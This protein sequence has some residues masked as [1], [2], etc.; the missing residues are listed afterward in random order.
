MGCVF[1]KVEM[2][3]SC[4]GFFSALTL[5]L[6][7]SLMHKPVFASEPPIPANWTKQ[8]N[9]AQTQYLAADGSALVLVGPEPN[10]GQPNILA[11]AE[12]T[13]K[14]GGCQGL[15]K[16]AVQTTDRGVQKLVLNTGPVFCAIFVDSNSAPARLAVAI[17]QGTNEAVQYAE[18]LTR[19]WGVAK[20]SA[21]N[22]SP[23]PSTLSTGAVQDDVALKNAMAAVPKSNR[24][25][26][27]AVQSD[28]LLGANGAMQMTT[29]NWGV[30][31]NGYATD[32]TGWDPA[33]ISPTPQSLG[34]AMQKAGKSCH[35]I[36][37]EKKQGNYVRFI[38]PENVSV[39]DE[40]EIVN[41]GFA[42]GTRIDVSIGN[43]RA[44][45]SVGYVPDGMVAARG[46]S[47]GSLR[48]T[49]AGAIE[50]GSWSSINFT[51]SDVIAGGSSSSS[52]P[53]AGRY[54]LD[55][56]VIAIQDQNG[57]ISR[58]MIYGFQNGPNEKYNPNGWYLTVDGTDYY[59]T[60]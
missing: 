34:V 44:F 7:P 22:N 16:Q 39:P 54:Y 21:V 15:T 42:P 14:P 18:R 38:A 49:K 9:G 5:A 25:I 8:V 60:D 30:F 41:E 57:V 59:P 26:G 4:R 36:R 33:E 23:M 10:G 27:Y 53:R 11:M 12:A 43:V 31:P 20:S 40:A 45:G 1:G 52:G 32:C 47:S 2:I 17:G 29:T 50:V 28:Y 19:D 13:D 51:G 6:L 37:W 48:M 3:K 46:L 56:Y 35:V 24:P 58:R 55:G